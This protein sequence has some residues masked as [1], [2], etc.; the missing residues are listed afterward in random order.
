MIGVRT[1]LHLAATAGFAVLAMALLVFTGSP[2]P[3]RGP[4]TPV[5]LQT[6]DVFSPFVDA[7]PSV[8]QQVAGYVLEPGETLADQTFVDSP[9]N[10]TQHVYLVGSRDREAI[11]TVT[12]SSTARIELSVEST[13]FGFQSSNRS[14]E[15][16]GDER[17]RP[18]S[19]PDR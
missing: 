15:R 17:T 19:R 10:G 9:L 5:Y 6:A 2:E 12:A 1:V 14:A 18:N 8:A 13:Q 4:D 11:L 7:S 3:G 16:S